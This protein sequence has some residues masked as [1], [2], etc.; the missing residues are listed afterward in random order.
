MSRSRSPT[1]ASSTPRS[2]LRDQRTDLVV[3]RLKGGENFPVMELGG[4]RCARSRRHCSCHRQSLW[5]RAD[6]DA[7]NCLGSGA[8]PGRHFGLR[9]FHSNRRGDQSRQFGRRSRRSSGAARRH[10]FRDLFANRKLDRNRLRHPR[11]YG[12][13][14]ACRRQGRRPSGAASLARREPASRLAGNR[15]FAWPRPADRALLSPIFPTG[16]PAAEAG[17]RRG[18]IVTAIDGQS[19]DDPEGLGYR[20]ATK[21]LGGAASFTYLRNGKPGTASVKLIPAPEIPARD[22]VKLKGGLAFRRRN[23]DQFVA[24]GLGG[25]LHSRRRAMALS[26]ARS[27]KVRGRRWSI[28][29]SAM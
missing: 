28:F 9:L 25:T 6:G 7:G 3:L 16:G 11:Q 19:I 20:L 14:R 26:S 8:H 21:S 17:L 2:C 13:N 10:Q 1:S 22:P 24:R 12:E 18:D 5:G 29:R 15:R 4:F 23:R 27:R